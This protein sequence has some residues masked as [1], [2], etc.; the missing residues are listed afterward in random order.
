MAVE[1]HWALTFVRATEIDS[2]LTERHYLSR[3]AF[4]FGGKDFVM[5][6]GAFHIGLQQPLG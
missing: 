5:A 3:G 4:S 2:G 6:P 1:R